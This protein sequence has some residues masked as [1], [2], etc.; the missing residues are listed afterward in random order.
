[1]AVQVKAR[2]LGREQSMVVT[3]QPTTEGKIWLQLSGLPVSIP[4]FS[5]SRDDLWKIIDELQGAAGR[6]AACNV[7]S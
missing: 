7:G 5:L 2:V 3:A 6:G 4:T 1:M